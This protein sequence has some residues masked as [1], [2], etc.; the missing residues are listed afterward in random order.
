MVTAKATKVSVDY[1]VE[2]KE[3]QKRLTFSWRWFKLTSRNGYYTALYGWIFL[4]LAPFF[5]KQDFR[6]WFSTSENST[7]A[8]A[9]TIAVVFSSAVYTSLRQIMLLTAGHKWLSKKTNPDAISLGTSVP[10]PSFLKGFSVYALPLQVSR[11]FCTY[12]H[13]CLKLVPN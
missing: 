9:D 1:H 11:P 3:G 2:M 5:S 4:L 8:Q 6:A 7:H 13:F 12:A 10:S